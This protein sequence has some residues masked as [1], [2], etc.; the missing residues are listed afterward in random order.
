MSLK[1]RGNSHQ[2][3]SNSELIELQS[4]LE[5]IDRGFMSVD[6]N[7]RIAYVN[8][9]AASDLGKKPSELVG[10]NLWAE[11]PELEGTNAAKTYREAMDRKC[12]AELEDF[13][14]LT[15]CW[16][17]QKAYP[18]PNGIVV[19]W[20]DITERKNT[21]DALEQAKNRLQ[22]I[23]NGIDDGITLVGLDGKVLDCNRASLQLLG[24]KFEEFV[25]TNVYDVI[26]PEDR[27]RAITGASEVLKTGKVVNEVRVKRKNGSTFFAEISVTALCDKSEKP[28]LFLGVTRDV[29]EHRK[30]ETALKLSEEKF[31]K[32]FL[33]SPFALTLT[34]L[35]DGKIVDANNSAA[36]LFGYERNEIIGRKTLEL[37][38][39]IEPQDRRRFIEE[40]TSKGA[41][42]NLELSLRKRAGAIS[43][44]L[45]SA[46]LIEIQGEKHFLSTFL[47]IT[48]RRRAEEALLEAEEK[49]RG[50]VESTSDIIWQVDENAVYT[51]VSPKVKDILGYEPEELVGNTPFDFVEEQDE[52]KIVD[53]FLEIANKKEP[54]YGLENWNVHKN[55]SRVLLE[56]SGVPILDENGQLAGYRGIDRDITERKK[57]QLELEKYTKDLEQLV[58]ER[59]RQLQEKERLAAIGQTAGMVGH[60]IRNPLQA[61]IGD[62]FIARQETLTMPDGE[63]K[64]GMTDTIAAIEENI[65]YINKIVSDLQDYTR[66]L[67]PSFKETDVKALLENIIFTV[68]IPQYIKTSLKVEQ[69]LTIS[70]DCD[71]LRRI[72]TNLVINAVQAMPNEGSLVVQVKSSKHN[73][74]VFAVEDTGVG[75][76]EDVKTKLFTPLFTTKSKGQGLG[77]A[78]VKRLVEG[79]KGSVRVESEEGM[80]TKFIIELPINK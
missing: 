7:W 71:Y 66:P 43:F 20:A 36:S 59:T 63:A 68:K 16:N 67:S 49:F 19:A 38:I 5:N 10:K 53:A 25:G 44:V 48:K 6:R 22:D 29:T 51:Y 50:L 21:E 55:G 4:I 78:V 57:L 42:Q 3:D 1:R 79:L 34:C 14:P 15:R 39:W 45:I 77:L 75:I 47:D 72:L 33:N 52:D 58:A 18:T 35:S 65:F 17:Q 40:L 13:S 23:L 56:T 54:F 41:V 27:Q 62:L 2:Y 73:R 76:P 60:D 12:A 8:P 32:A 24:L 74:V 69:G 80:G 64:Q 28:T 46:S 31:S 37:D 9:Q 61:I 26:V 11:Y 30:L 70:T